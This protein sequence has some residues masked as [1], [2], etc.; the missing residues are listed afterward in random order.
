MNKNVFIQFHFAAVRTDQP[1]R[2][3]EPR[4]SNILLLDCGDAIS[5]AMVN[6]LL[7]HLGSIGRVFALYILELY[8]IVAWFVFASVDLM[9]KVPE[10]SMSP[11]G[12]S[13]TPNQWA[14]GT[15]IQ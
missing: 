7:R 15:K 5:V 11:R 1:C 6:S 14:Y 4:V 3:S 2:C 12:E 10:Y 13:R 9:F 8:E